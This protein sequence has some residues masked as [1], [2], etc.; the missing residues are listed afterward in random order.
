MGTSSKALN[1]T[2]FSTKEEFDDLLE[3]IV[4]IIDKYSLP[5]HFDVKAVESPV[6][7]SDLDE[8]WIAL[9]PGTPPGQR[10]VRGFTVAEKAQIT[11]PEKADISVLADS[12][13]E[14]IAFTF[15]DSDD[16]STNKVTYHQEIAELAA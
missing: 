10:A 2:I 1:V 4:G 3:Y 13:A 8:K 11:D 16:G 7:D 14:H 6:P 9:N 5:D 12:V 15:S